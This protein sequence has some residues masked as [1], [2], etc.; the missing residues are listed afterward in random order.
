MVKKNTIDGLFPLLDWILKKKGKLPTDLNLP[1]SFLINR[2]LSMTDPSIAQIVNATSNRWI[3]KTELAKD[4]HSI[5]KFFY[6]V[7][8]KTIKKISYIK[9]SGKE[10]NNEDVTDTAT[11]MECSTK[12]IEFYNKTLAELNGKLK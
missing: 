12:E 2:W 9:K 5:Y 3:N 11:S 1:G 10:Y 6:L 7:L 4:N 8:P